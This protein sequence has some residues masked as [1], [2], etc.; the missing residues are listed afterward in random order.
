VCIAQSLTL[1]WA[2]SDNLDTRQARLIAARRGD[3]AKGSQLCLETHLLFSRTGGHL[4]VVSPGKLV[5]LELATSATSVCELSNERITSACW[6][7]EATLGCVSYSTPKGDG[8][9]VARWVWRQKRDEAIEKRV[10]IYNDLDIQFHVPT[11]LDEGGEWPFEYWSADGRN[12][13]LHAAPRWGR[14]QV[15]AIET[16][17]VRSYGPEDVGFTRASWNRAGTRVVCIVYGRAE[18]A[19]R[20]FLLDVTKEEITDL[21]REFREMFPKCEPDLDRYWTP[22]DRFLVGSNLN[23]GGYLIQPRPWEVRLLGKKLLGGAQV[24]PPFVRSQAAPGLLIFR[25]VAEEVVIDYEGNEVKSLGRKAMSGWT[26]LPDGKR[27]VSVW[28]GNKLVMETIK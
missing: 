17:A 1:Y 28:L 24:N 20:A 22:D 6:L 3:E 12:V 27:V 25:R 14:V 4:A 13:V 5:F 21:S 23:S 9:P 26:I 2:P 18:E 8:D 16:G 10:V 19:Y 11:L 7:D 15:L